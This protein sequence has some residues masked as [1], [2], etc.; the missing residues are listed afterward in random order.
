MKHRILQSHY[1]YLYIGICLLVSAFELQA[2]SKAT[3]VGSFTNV[4]LE[5]AINHWKKEY[6]LLFA[7]DHQVINNVYV[8]KE[9]RATTLQEAMTKLLTSTALTFRIVEESRILIYQPTSLPEEPIPEYFT[10][11]GKVIDMATKEPLPFANIFIASGKGTSSDLNGYFS[12][13][14]LKD[15]ITTLQIQYIGYESIK[16]NVSAATKLP[17]RITMQPQPYQIQSI[18]VLGE[19]PSISNQSI[20]QATTIQTALLQRLPTVGVGTD[21]FRALQLLPGI[22]AFDDRSSGIS[23]RG[24]SDVENLVILDGITLLKTDHFYGIF[25]AINTNAIE[26]VNIYKNAFPSEY[27]G[28][29]AGILDMH[30][31]TVASHNKQWHGSAE[32][33]L[34]TADA[35]LSI[36][37]GKTMSAFVA[38]RT[39]THEIKDGNFINSSEVDRS[40]TIENLNLFMDTIASV[41]RIKNKQPSINFND[42]TGKWLWQPNNQHKLQLTYFGSKD[43]FLLAFKDDFTTQTL[44][45][46]ID[47]IVEYREKNAWTN[48]GAS[49]QWYAT[50]REDFQSKLVLSWSELESESNLT[51]SLLQSNR[52]RP[53]DVSNEAYNFNT[54]LSVNWKNVWQINPQQRFQFGYNGVQ[55]RLL[56]DLGIDRQRS[57]SVNN[58]A[59]ENTIFSEYYHQSSKNWNITLGMRAI[60]Y[61]KTDKFYFSPRFQTNYQILEKW[62][63]KASA[64][65]YYQFL[66]E[67]YHEDRFGRKL[68]YYIL[69]GRDFPVLTANQFMLGANYLGKQFEVDVEL[70]DKQMDGI[71]EYAHLSPGF[72]NNATEPNRSLAYQIFVGS[73]RI[74]GID[75]LLR[76][77]SGAYQG[78]IAY[79]LSKSVNQFETVNENEPYLAPNDRRHQLKLVN[80]YELGRWNFSGTYIFAS[81]KNYLDVSLLN[82]RDRRTLPFDRFLKQVDNYHRV[83]LGVHYQLPVRSTILDFGVSVFNLLNTDNI[84]YRQFIYTILER[85]TNGLKR[86]NT[87]I[88]NDVELLDR[89]LNLSIKW[90]F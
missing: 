22:S 19:L 66:R 35:T 18:T 25:S 73:G 28:R 71:T 44:F 33:N 15:E 59:S 69:A 13:S 68:E 3:Y 84:I 27:G 41:P 43:N 82:V 6:H 31:K 37:I 89:T 70:Y 51:S 74:Q 36:P 8:N 9:I 80:L 64:S 62:Q 88:G 81:G 78:W 52:F 55:H 1:T 57:L 67:T 79:T 45:G 61:S 72:D 85:D 47:N 20:S 11:N 21:L 38:A 58:N 10:I 12:L 16:I 26:E 17:L 39:T 76:K 63:L 50:W 23:I 46:S 86:Q 65:K 48:R 83:D 7:Y 34:L 90:K 42:F 40:A 56:L 87:P 4:T 24:S 54:N 5:D 29:T 75:L 53:I 32:L 30:T 60:Q 49:L 77:H 14:L 2:Q